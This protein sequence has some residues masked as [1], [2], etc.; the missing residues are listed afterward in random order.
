[1]D[2]IE[3][4]REIG[5]AIQKDDRFV[6][7]RT[8]EQAAEED[9]DLQDLIGQYN[10]K[11]M[12]LQNELQKQER[13]EDKV[14]SYQQSM[15]ALYESIMKNPHMETYSRARVDFDGLMRR[16]NAII[17]QSAQGADPETADY[18]ESACAGDCS[19]CAGCH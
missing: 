11:H 7:M 2:I 8:A 19:A 4:A 1:M 3:Q 14:K 10:L 13:D 12:S 16:V 5:K 9:K 17:Q 18:T 6:K 15:N